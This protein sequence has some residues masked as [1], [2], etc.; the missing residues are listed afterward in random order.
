MADTNALNSEIAVEPH[1]LGRRQFVAGAVA[2]SCMLSLPA[3]HRSSYYFNRRIPSEAHEQI[4][5]H[6]HNGITTFAFTPS[7]G[8]VLATDEGPY[9]ARNIPEECYQKLGEFVA[10]GA[11]INCIAFPP[12]GGNSWVIC[13]NQGIFARGIPEECYQQMLTYLRNGWEIKHVAFPPAGGNSW[14]IVTDGP[15]YARNID[16]ECYQIMRNLTQGGRTVTRVVFSWSNNGWVVIAEDEFFFRR[17]DEECYQKMIE[18]TGAGWLGHNVAF[19]PVNN[20]WALYS[21]GKAGNTPTDLVRAVESSLKNANGATS[22]IW[23]RM[24]TYNVPGCAVAVVLNNQLAWSC[25]Y[26]YLE[27]GDSLGAA[28]PESRFQA[29]SVSKPIA[30]AGVMKLLEETNDLALNDDIRPGLNWTLPIRSC[31]TVNGTPTINRVLQHMGGIIGRNTTNPLNVCSGFNNGGGGFAGYPEGQNVPTL[32]DIMNGT[33]TNSL[34]FELTTDPGTGFAYSGQGFVLLQRLIEQISGSG[35]ANYLD[36]EIFT[37]LGMQNSTYD[38]TLPTDWL[39]QRQVAAGHTSAGNVIAGKRNQYPE[40]AAAGLYTSVDDLMKM[41]IFLNSKWSNASSPGPLTQASV[42][43]LLSGLAWF[44][45]NSPSTSSDYSYGHNGANY[46][47]RSAVKGYPNLGAGYAVLTN[48]DDG[49]LQTEVANAIESVY[50]W[51]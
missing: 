40:S 36:T 38:I 11:E 44:P 39:S 49:T 20:G 47:F 29:A 3:C 35:F 28:H 5:V 51:T 16:D 46:G 4:G 22:N 12:A 27:Q 19:S 7:N 32:L 33:N 2:A 41:V 25:G 48:G 15:F 30:A 43:S 18:M 42:Q 23:S 13:T 21:R 50:G 17:I 9:F 37:P 1:K 14:V 31:L 10:N 24:S 8:W 34:P 45:N 6:A 26:G